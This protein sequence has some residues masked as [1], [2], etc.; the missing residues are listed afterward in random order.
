M[1]A[2][3][4]RA[5]CASSC[6]APPPPLRI[7]AITL[8]GDREAALRRMF[9]SLPDSDSIHL[10]ISPG[11]RAEEAFATE[12]SAV[13]AA[14]SCGLIRDA[15]VDRGW[16]EDFCKRVRG[17]V[18]SEKRV[19]ACFFAHLMAMRR[20]VSEGW[21]VVIEDN[22]R[23]M[24]CSTSS[25]SS[26][27]SSSSSSLSSPTSTSSSSLDA[28][29]RGF[30]TRL[31]AMLTAGNDG[32]G[33]G[34]D[35]PAAV[36]FFGWLGPVGHVQ[37]A[38][39]D[40]IPSHTTAALAA[41]AVAASRAPGAASGTAPGTASG[42]AAGTAPDDS[43][44]SCSS[45][46]DSASRGMANAMVPYPA[47]VTNS[48]VGRYGQHGLAPDGTPLPDLMRLMALEEAA[49]RGAG[50]ASAATASTA[51]RA[52]VFRGLTPEA[53]DALLENRGAVVVKLKA[54]LRAEFGIVERKHLAVN[55]SKIGGTVT[56][57]TR[58]HVMSAAAASLLKRTSE[59]GICL[60][61]GEV[62]GSGSGGGG[63]GGILGSGVAS[64]TATTSSA[65]RKGERAAKNGW[66][67][68][69]RKQ[70]QQRQQLEAAEAAAAAAAAATPVAKQLQEEPNRA[71]GACGE[72]DGAG[73]GA[74]LGPATSGGSG[75]AAANT[76][77]TADTAGTAAA[78]AAAAANEHEA[79]GG[80]DKS[81]GT[82][83]K[84]FQPLWGL[85][86]YAPSAAA[87]DAV[88]EGIRGDIVKL[89]WRGRRMKAGEYRARP[90]DKALPQ[91]LQ[92]AAVRRR[93]HLGAMRMAAR[94]LFFRA[95][96]LPSTLHRQ[97]D[98]LFVASTEAQLAGMGS[99]WDDL[100]LLE[101]ERAA[102]VEG[103]RQ[104]R[105]G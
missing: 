1:G 30:A 19:L 56:L 88:V 85:Y 15:K 84:R 73:A 31:R 105:E 81:A 36:R 54:E 63:G 49:R 60:E 61:P 96:M 100:W 34:A 93:H 55:V 89:L 39:R 25:T 64:A 9:A 2:P 99:S 75:T 69:K 41:A 35:G 23:V 52:C 104:R 90:V 24:T 27:S 3:A 40:H 21:D 22:V 5:P 50:G 45:G 71:E 14:T 68:R 59:L 4:P 47:L 6:S 43:G 33:E 13:A 37:W 80:C 82:S 28:G 98:R 46:S 101:E 51:L 77:N 42:A 95:P 97:Y 53:G 10:G 12:A 20:A 18:P 70:R 38:M 86:A 103:G 92:N 44:S 91:L 58:G 66:S 32:H 78:A 16:I 94:P 26:S 62:E 29:R 74:S 79:K 48:M 8:G 102:A 72:I 76:A 17:L 67:R 7:L 87:V 57:H 11:V 83:E 65:V